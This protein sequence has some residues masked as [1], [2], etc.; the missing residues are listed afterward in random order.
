MRKRVTT[1]NVVKRPQAG[2]GPRRSMRPRLGIAMGETRVRRGFAGPVLGLVV[3]LICC[4]A[5][6]I[7][8]LGVE[9]RL[10]ADLAD[11]AEAPPPPTVRRWRKSTS[12]PP[13]HSPSSCAGRRRRSTGRGPPWSARFDATRPWP[14]SLP[15]TEVRSASCGP[16]PAGR[17]SYSTTTCRSTW[18]CVK[19]CRRSN[20]P[21]RRASTRRWKRSSRATPASRER[22]SP[23]R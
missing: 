15:G 10:A 20:A 14:S 22:C 3:V 2:R 11:R 9:D 21:C 8:G 19:R 18:P 6:G 7:A 13:R 1:T 12:A 4:V 5:L 17:S 23:N 16:A